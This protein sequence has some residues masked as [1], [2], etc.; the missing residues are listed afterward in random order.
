MDS[1]EI[2][3][4]NIAG[5]IT[6]SNN[7]Q[8]TLK[9]WREIFGL[10]QKDLAS[11]LKISPSVISDYES[12]RRIS[13]GTGYVRKVVEALIKLDSE[14]GRE[15]SGKFDL[16]ASSDAILDIREFL[17]PVSAERFLKAV[18]GK[19]I[20][21][22]SILK[23]T[24]L[25]GYTLIDSIQA[26]MKLSEDDF[27]RIYGSTTE[28]A[29]IF[30]K[31]HLGRSPMIA[32]KVTPPKPK[33]IILHGLRPENVDKLAIKIALMEKIPLAVSTI[34]TEEGLMEKLRKIN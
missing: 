8:A 6:L 4:K 25:G 32:V 1:Q 5:E 27:V 2:L 3:A 21:N 15:V 13:P 28:R 31:V 24:R 16:K 18:N 34:K 22:R 12:G 11:A 30:T 19:V 14:R 33:M 23:K 7:P 20:A 9:K 26:I 17:T 29:L 10:S